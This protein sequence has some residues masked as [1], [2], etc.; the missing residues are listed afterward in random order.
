MTK[1]AEK[2]EIKTA[3]NRYC[4]AKGISKNELATL[5]EISAAT[6]SNIETEKWDSIDPKMWQKI[7]N[8]V[9]RL[10][11]VTIFKTKDCKAIED[12]CLTARK[13]YLMIGLI[14]DTGM[15][16]TT[17]LTSYSHRTKHTYFISFDKTM[18]PKQFF[19]ALLKEMAI[20][21]NGNINEMVN[22]IADELNVMESPLIII[23]EAGKLTDMMILYLQVLKDKTQLGCG[24]ILA[25]MP[26][27]KTKLIKLANKQKE[28]YAEFL[29]RVN[30]WHELEGLNRDEIKFICEQSGVTA[31]DLQREFLNKK[32]FGDLVNALLLKRLTNQN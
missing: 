20:P 24:F 28:G 16:K 13:N 18:R 8:K 32:R 26:Y 22:R 23:D 27:F 5:L 19:A 1:L 12:M 6:L 4:K 9:G 30:I 3:V 11:D 25:G 29:R 14:A 7:W 17:A 15:G 31:P 21:F 2:S 10:N